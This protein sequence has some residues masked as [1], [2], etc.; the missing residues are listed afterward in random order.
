MW[1]LT[2]CLLIACD[3]GNNGG[4]AT[5]QVP[6]GLSETVF[7]TGDDP[8]GPFFTS[9]GSNQRTCASCHDRDAGWSLS[10]AVIAARFD[11][12]DGT[13]PLFRA[14]DGAH[15]PGADTS[16]S[17]ARRAAY[18]LLLS[19]GLIRV[20]QPIPASA[21]FELA[22]VSDPFGF[23]SAAQLSLFRRPLPSTNLRFVSQIM[24]DT[25]EPGLA[26]QATDATLGHAQAMS[27]DPS[28][29]TA[30]AGFEAQIYTAERSDDTAGDLAADGASGG[31]TA[32]VS[33]T[34]A[35]GDFT[36]FSAWTN[37]ADARRA[38]IARGQRLFNNEQLDIRNV[39]GIANQRG[40]CSTCHDVANVG[41]RF[42]ADPLDIGVADEDQDTSELPRY[43][44]RDLATGNT[45][46][47]TDPGLA[48]VTGKWADI[49]RFK[50][51]VLRGLAMRP[52]YFHNGR[53]ANLHEVIKFYEDHFDL[54]LSNG[55]ET[56]LEAFL[57]AL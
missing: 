22:S 27:V 13:D 14:V 51:P 47:T 17:L 29:M 21:E 40:M 34:A 55:E 37:S 42:E 11:A 23:A 41:N 35:K 9:L 5:I 31:A 32:L 56:D 8:T 24:W 46:T 2:L 18:D 28:V 36:L 52:P 43:T 15:A 25:R 16:T 1:K 54:H 10:P 49:G 7:A 4:D 33:L 57:S 12:T 6:T 53:A 19:R 3:D 20:G 30:I 38:S 39:A 50:V 48:L 45:V 26:M 44:L